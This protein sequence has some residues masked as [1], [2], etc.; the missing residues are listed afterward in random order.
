MNN[1][2][3]LLRAP[4]LGILVAELGVHYGRA[5][6]LDYDQPAEDILGAVMAGIGEV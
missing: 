3:L 2:A 4:L 5:L 1:A 6:D